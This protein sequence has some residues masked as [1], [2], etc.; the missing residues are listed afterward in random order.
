YRATLSLGMAQACFELAGGMAWAG[1]RVFE[2]RKASAPVILAGPVI[3]ALALY[4]P[5]IDNSFIARASL[6]SIVIAAYYSA[7]T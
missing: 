2:G 5:G 6:S 1:V 3:W 7:I 4:I